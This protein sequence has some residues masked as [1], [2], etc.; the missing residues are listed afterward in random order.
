MEKGINELS[1]RKIMEH[2][3]NYSKID[4]LVSV[5]KQQGHY[6]GR[7]LAT[8]RSEI[9]NDK[10]FQYLNKAAMATIGRAKAVA[11]FKGIKSSGFFA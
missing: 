11:Q 5:A 4:A 3:I 10:P 6:L 1:N 8:D 7:L 9:K 2:R